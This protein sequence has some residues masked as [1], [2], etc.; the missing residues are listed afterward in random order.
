MCDVFVGL[1]GLTDV[2]TPQYYLA[3]QQVNLD[4]KVQCFLK[5]YVMTIQQV[6]YISIFY[7][8]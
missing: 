8:V 6:Y 4:K 2:V 7:V 3:G 5:A 1:P